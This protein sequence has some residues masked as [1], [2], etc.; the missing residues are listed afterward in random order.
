MTLVTKSD[1]TSA[2]VAKSKTHNSRWLTPEDRERIRELR[3]QN[4]TLDEIRQITGYTYLT[5]WKT[6]AGITGTRPRGRKP[7]GKN[8]EK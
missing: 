1:S 8:R 7:G 3:T 6:C 2:Y 5:V 4:L